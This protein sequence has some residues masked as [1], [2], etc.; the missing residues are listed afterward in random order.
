MFIA[1]NVLG[2]CPTIHDL[3]VDG[4]S[5][6][7][8][9]A[10]GTV[11]LSVKGIQMPS[12][13]VISWMYSDDPNFDP[14]TEGTLIGK[15]DLP[16]HQKVSCPSVCPDLLMVMMNSCD[17][18]GKEENNEF[19]I[20]SSGSGFFA[21][22]LQFRINE[23]T[24][25]NGN[26]NHSV[27]IGSN[28]CNIQKPS[29]AFMTRLRSGACSNLNL[30][31]AGPGDFIPP[32]A[33][34]IFFM[35]NNVTIDYNLNT[36]CNSGHNVYVMQSSCA[37][38]MGAFT[39][40]LSNANSPN[41]TRDNMFSL[42]NCTS[43]RDSVNYTLVGARNQEGEY[44]VDKDFQYHSVANGSVLL[45][46][47]GDP[48]Q[49]PD[50]SNY[51]K[52]AT[53]YTM[54]FT[55]ANNSP[56][57]G[58]RVYFKAY[59]TPS[60]EAICENIIAEGAYLDIACGGGDVKATAP[61]NICS[62]NALKIEFDI[63]GN[64]KWTVTA[65]AGVTGLISGSGNVQN[66]QQT[67]V[68]NG[69]QPVVVSYKLESLS[70][71]CPSNPITLNITVGPSLTSAISGKTSLCAGEQ[72]TLS[73]SGSNAQVIW[74]TGATSNSIVVNQSGT[75][76]VKVSNGICESESS[77][78]VKISDA[79]QVTIAGKLEICKGETTTLTIQENFDKYEWSN[80]QTAKSAQ[81][82][83]P[84]NYSVKVTSGN[85]SV[86]SPIV[87]KENSSLNVTTSVNPVTCK[88]DDGS[89]TVVVNDPIA[90]TILWNTGETTYTISNKAAG[91]YTYVISYLTCTVEGKVVI[92]IDPN[93][94]TFEVDVE[95]V[96]CDGLVNGTL[97]FVNIQNGEA[98][99]LYFVDGLASTAVVTDLEQGVYNVAV[100]DAKGCRMEQSVTVTQAPNVNVN[101]PQDL[102]VY[103]GQSVV[104]SAQ[105]T[106]AD[107]RKEENIYSWTP[108]FG[109]NCDDCEQPVATPLETIEY[110]FTVVNVFGCEDT[111]TILVE[112]KPS[113]NVFLP[114]AF[115]PNRDGLNDI[116]YIFTK[117]ED[118]KI[119]VFEIFNRWGISVFRVENVDANNPVFGWDGTYQGKLVPVDNYLYY[120]EVEFADKTI[121][122]KEGSVLIVR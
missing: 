101:F 31:S 110:I 43:C 95:P 113:L 77:V 17:G 28:P 47:Q 30:F 104:L 3:K 50:L 41:K 18:K 37:R 103:E 97:S 91:E 53:P 72:T 93:A 83:Q 64:Y 111:D 115:S 89:A 84:G 42:K 92:P 62:G 94:L 60:D 61:A 39:N 52:P 56:L 119:K 85:C 46:T 116:F 10:P 82:S 80:G 2:Q 107:I 88:G 16:E 40:V 66:I 11:Q 70:S 100:V 38:T 98:P 59:V 63:L 55:V 57:C 1:A 106:G 68:Y 71:A 25:G 4:K 45:N 15:T 87:I 48:C 67:P 6:T 79:L 35:S 9:C 76:S 74:S 7:S 33:L 24:N 21:S 108:T 114:K 14:R 102:T 20:L 73:V 112:V 120:F 12:K 105:I 69:T 32:D 90:N 23:A 118:V 54:N 122:Q 109:L 86:T 44:I 51:M 65:P 121:Y 96:S 75:Y 81:F 49:T 5:N 117:N 78:D 13:G 34:V 29:E 27:N 26:E 8:I 58:K 36:L 99:F 22:D 19:F